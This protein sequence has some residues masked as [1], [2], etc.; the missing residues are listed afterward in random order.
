MRTAASPSWSRA[1]GPTR[2]SLGRVRW[3]TCSFV[4]FPW[5]WACA[6][7][8]VDGRPPRP[9]PSHSATA[10]AAATAGRRRRDRPRQPERRRGT[11]RRRDRSMWWSDV[12]SPVRPAGIAWRSASS[13]TLRFVAAGELDLPAF[14][15]RITV[16]TSS[17]ARSSADIAGGV[18]PAS[19]LSRRSANAGARAFSARRRLGVRLG[20]RAVENVVVVVVVTGH[21]RLLELPARRV[22]RTACETRA[23]HG[24][25]ARRTYRS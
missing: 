6:T 5:L 14:A 3:S 12:R 15:A 21:L 4:V 17:S 7:G 19:V 22:R 23:P 9:A 18:R 20:D 24:T 1:I 16:A 10:A 13:T 11:A 2:E 25:A 8:A